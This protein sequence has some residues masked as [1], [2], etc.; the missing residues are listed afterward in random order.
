MAGHDLARVAA[1]EFDPADFFADF[2]AEAKLFG[3]I[4]LIDLLTGGSLATDAPKVQLTTEELGPDRRKVV[5]TLT[6][7]P[8]VRSASVGIVSLNA[9]GASFE[10]N[11]RVERVVQLAPTGP[12]ESR[13]EFTGVLSDF[14]LDL[15]NVV[16]LRFT[17][18]R[19]VSVSGAKP[20]VQVALEDDPLGF[21][22]DLEFV[23]E[24]KNVIPPGLFGDGASLDVTPTSVRAGFG[25]GLPPISIGIFSL[26]GVNLSAAVELPFADGKPLFDFAV[27]SREHP[28][29][30]TVAFLGGGGFF[31]LQLDTQGI[32]LLEAALEFGASASINLG[33]ASGGV[34]IMAGV[35]FAMGRRDNQ[36]FSIL[37]GFLRMGGELSVL[38]L[39]SISLEFVLSFGYEAGKAAGRA[40]LTVKV[41]IAFFSKSVEI[42]VEK[43]FGGSSGDPRFLDVVET[44]AVWSEYASAFA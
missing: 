21:Q 14:H 35:Y 33:V 29:C 15:L 27:S 41:E 43:K 10:V 16:V 34:H 37:S 6:W 12:E 5:A 25:I 4:P 39:I 11:G 38:G 8:G 28:F 19:F 9:D 13:S 44:P 31:H 1:G 2:A 32:R 26:E 22:G 23:N 40:T 3:T 24:L 18:F 17:S 36:D 7:R 42:S 30:L 20:V